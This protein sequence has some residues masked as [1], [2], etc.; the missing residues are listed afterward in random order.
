MDV[1]NGR[2]KSK[3]RSYLSGLNHVKQLEQTEV[4]WHKSVLRRSAPF[5]ETN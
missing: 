1:N 5:A 2:G 3:I 4:R